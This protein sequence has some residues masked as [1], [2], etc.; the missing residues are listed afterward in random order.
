MNFP[1]PIRAVTNAARDHV[2]GQVNG[3]VNELDGFLRER[4][5]IGPDQ[6]SRNMTGEIDAIRHAYTLGRLTQDYNYQIAKVMGN[7]HERRNPNPADQQR[8]DYHNN[9][10]GARYGNQVINDA[11][12]NRLQAGET[13]Q[14]RLF[15][16]VLRGARDGE[17]ITDPTQTGPRVGRLRADAGDGA[18]L[19]AIDP[20]QDPRQQGTL[21][22]IRRTPGMQNDQFD[23]RAV[24]AFTLTAAEK[25][26]KSPDFAGKN[27][28]GTGF[29]VK[30]D[31]LDSPTAE[32]VKVSADKMQWPEAMSMARVDGLE[33]QRNLLAASAPAQTPQENPT[34]A[35]EGRG[36]AR[37]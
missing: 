3:Y 36:M 9:D 33:T 32:I 26:W 34:M 17:L 24:A 5:M 29:V 11:H 16:R 27:A 30:A 13:I 1:N 6:S 2:N 18:V 8:M 23:P 22:A 28:D 37:G 21:D 35:L 10:M 19:A 25:E 15:E 4:G 14:E 7:E 12:R 20:A 31:R